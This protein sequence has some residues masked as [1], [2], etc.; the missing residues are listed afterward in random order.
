MPNGIKPVDTLDSL[1]SVGSAY[2]SGRQPGTC[3]YW[4]LDLGRRLFWM[5]S[6]LFFL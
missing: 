6:L 2:C 3:K 5:L 4:I 1:S